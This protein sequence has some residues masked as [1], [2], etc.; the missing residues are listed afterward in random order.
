MKKT[1]IAIA[2]RRMGLALGVLALTVDKLD[3]VPE[4]QRALYVERDGKFHLDVSGYED[5]AGVKTALNAE[6]K[7]RADADKKAK[8]LEELY[9]GIDPVKYRETIAKFQDNEEAALIAAG[10][11][12]EVINRRTEKLRKEFEKQIKEAKDGQ[13]GAIKSRDKYRDKVLGDSVRAAATK[14][15]MHGSAVDDAILRA[16]GIFTVDDDGV[17]IQLDSAGEPV[18]GKDGKT[19]FTVAEWMEGMKETAPHWFPAANNGSGANGNKKPGDG[20]TMSRKQYDALPTADQRK[21]VTVEKGTV[22]D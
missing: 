8:A 13:S 7:A 12:D 14:A 16:K 22:V 9:A 15:G 4:P 5:P 19:N 1:L 21:F 6:R 11:I 2:I 10:K 18:L 20:K 3:A 17:A